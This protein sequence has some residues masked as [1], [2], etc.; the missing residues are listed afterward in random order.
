MGLR[1]AAEFG[2]GS[3]WDF[4]SAVKRSIFKISALRVRGRVLV[5]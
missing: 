3:M 2:K 1:E 4:I 5:N